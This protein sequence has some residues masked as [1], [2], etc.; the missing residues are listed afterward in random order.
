[1]TKTNKHKKTKDNTHTPTHTHTH[2]HIDIFW[3]SRNKSDKKH[4]SWLDPCFFCFFC[5]SALSD[6]LALIVLHSHVT[7]FLVAIETSSASAGRCAD[8]VAATGAV[9]ATPDVREWT[10]RGNSVEYLGDC[11]GPR[12]RFDWASFIKLFLS[13]FFPP[14]SNVVK[15]KLTGAL[16]CFFLLPDKYLHFIIQARIDTED[17]FRIAEQQKVSLLFPVFVKKKKLNTNEKQNKTRK[18]TFLT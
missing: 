14:S 6:W 18:C 9:I 2:T 7:P 16:V 10:T 11:R 13:S 1:M 8:N 12:F 3:Q 4:K 17:S 5:P 15:R